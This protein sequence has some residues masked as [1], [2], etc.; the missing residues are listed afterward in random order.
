MFSTATV[1]S[2]GFI[3]S[4]HGRPTASNAPPWGKE[5]R[6]GWAASDRLAHAQ[7]GR[8]PAAQQHLRPDA[9]IVDGQV[10]WRHLDTT[11]GEASIAPGDAGRMMVLPRSGRQIKSRRIDRRKQSAERQGASRTPSNLAE[12]RHAL[13]RL[14][15]DRLQHRADPFVVGLQRGAQLVR[16]ARQRGLEA[17]VLRG[18]RAPP[19]APAPSGR[20]RGS[21]P[22]APRAGRA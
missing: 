3:F 10:S 1:P 15:A 20:P 13:L 22:A 2:R 6:A 18:A 14:E 11:A 19:A 17:D 9:E 7:S 16:R 8:R 21:A 4:A 12:A 5:S